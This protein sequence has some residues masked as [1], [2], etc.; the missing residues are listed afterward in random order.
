M[1]PALLQAARADLDHLAR[2]PQ[3]IHNRAESTVGAG[4]ALGMRTEWLAGIVRGG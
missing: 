2:A 1:K 3:E 4:I